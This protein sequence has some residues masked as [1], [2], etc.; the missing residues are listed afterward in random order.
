MKIIFFT[1]KFPRQNNKMDGIFN[2]ERAVA[3]KQLGH[4]V[5][6]ISPVSL[7]PGKRL[8]YP[9]PRFKKIKEFIKKNYKIPKIEFVQ[10]FKVYHPIWLWLPKNMFWFSESYFLNIFAGRMINNV[11]KDIE[12]DLIISSW[13][14]PLGTYS[15]YIKKKHNIIFFTIPEGDDIIYYP[16]K[17]PGWKLIEKTINKYCDAVICVSKYIY[18]EI[19]KK[20]NLKNLYIINNGFEKTL[21]KYQIKQKKNTN[22]INLISVGYLGFVKGHD[23]LL[24]SLELLDDKFNLT[25]IGNGPFFDIYKRF[26]ELKNLKKRVNFIKQVNHEELPSYYKSHDIFCMPSR[27]ESFG[28]SILEA[29]GCG[30]PVVGTSIGGIKEKI[31]NNFNGFLCKPESPEDMANKIMEASKGHWNHQK[32]SKWV[33]T[34]YGWDKWGKELLDLYNN[35]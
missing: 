13:I 27:S 32:I 21:F 24:K 14:H 18:E 2:F 8:F 6:I 28:V 26:I 33:H 9:I 3:L 30:L 10:G 25:L 4:D 31:I 35:I 1:S 12:P 16:D 20:R 15:K 17:Y 23:V 5:Q 22:E 19:F 34:N 11:I 7:T 29:M